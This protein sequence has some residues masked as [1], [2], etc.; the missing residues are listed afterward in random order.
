MTFSNITTAWLIIGMI[1]YLALYIKKLRNEPDK[2]QSYE[3]LP[4]I[5]R[6]FGAVLFI[7]IWPLALLELLLGGSDHGE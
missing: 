4:Q 3:E 7:V 2:T 6:F 5:A 1:V